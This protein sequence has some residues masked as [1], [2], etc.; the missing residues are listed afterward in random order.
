M[1]WPFSLARADKKFEGIKEMD[2]I[3]GG[4]SFVA[5]V[6][7]IS[8]LRR[9][10][11]MQAQISRKMEG[12]LRVALGRLKADAD[13]NAKLMKRMSDRILKIERRVSLSQRA[14]VNARAELTK[15]K[16]ENQKLRAVMPKRPKPQLKVAN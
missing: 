4:F 8:A 16:K 5:V 6:I 12:T 1:L 9:I 11:G 3:L 14:E 10:T 13:E 15:L 2:W 7:A